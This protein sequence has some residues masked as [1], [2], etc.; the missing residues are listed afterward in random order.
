MSTEAEVIVKL[1]SPREV[2]VRCEE[3]VT[4]IPRVVVCAKRGGVGWV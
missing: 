1:V 3:H 2:G 4:R